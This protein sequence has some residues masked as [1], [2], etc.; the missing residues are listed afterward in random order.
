MHKSLSG[1]KILFVSLL[2][3]TLFLNS[4][5]VSAQ[6][7]DYVAER[8]RAIQLINSKNYA[9]AQPLLEKL[10]ADK[11]ADG[12]IFLGLGITYWEAHKPIK[13]KNQWK[14]MRLKARAAFVKAA[15]MSASTPQIDALVATIKSDGGER[16]TSD[17]P[18]AQ[19]AM[20]EAFPPF[21]AGDFQKALAAYEKAA[22]L[23]PTLYEAALYTGNTYYRLKDYEKAGV[24]FAKAI[25]IDPNRETAYRYWADGLMLS[26]KNKEAEEKFLD[27]IIAEPYNQFSWRG[28]TYYAQR[29]NIK[30][31]HPKIDNPVQVTFDENGN[32]KINMSGE[33][34]LAG[35]DD[36]TLAWTAYGLTRSTWRKEKFAR[37]FPGEKNY[38]YTVSEEVDS[39]RSVLAM[40]D[41]KKSLIKNLSPS[42]A[43]L[44]SLSEA[45][46]LEAY[47]LFTRA[48]PGIRRDYN[49]YCQTNRDKLKRYL[50]EYVLKN[51]GVSES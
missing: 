9:E 46:L 41:E 8:E 48:N 22:T 14:Q 37:Q 21:A 51:G 7:S 10:A 2:F 34:I 17:N 12:Q 44:K 36:G 33:A 26:G 4:A 28:L 6:P 47:I 38:R 43:T 31:G 32:P 19:A 42:L 23:D 49:S 11:R 40:A 18:Q 1:L 24:W 29:N 30:L 35:K 50:T 16:G 27:A 39:L 5:N 20:D 3:S 13:D 25:A 15:E 45:G